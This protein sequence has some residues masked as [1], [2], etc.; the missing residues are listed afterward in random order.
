LGP[1]GVYGTYTEGT[2]VNSSI[3][4]PEPS[5]LLL[6]AIGSLALVALAGRKL[7]A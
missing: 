6:F 2:W 4:T 7:T 5:S 3:S 1:G